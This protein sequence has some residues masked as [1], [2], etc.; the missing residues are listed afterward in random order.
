[1]Q[2]KIISILLILYGVYL[3]TIGFLNLQKNKKIFSV[4]ELLDLYIIKIKKGMVA[5][6]SRK[7]DLL[8]TSK[9]KIFAKSFLF[10]GILSLV[11]GLFLLLQ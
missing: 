2:D 10:L 7:N 8:E 3:T 6:E 5:Y 9:H 11:L 4:L 1:M